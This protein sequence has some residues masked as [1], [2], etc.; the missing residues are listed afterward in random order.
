[1]D[2][3]IVVGLVF[4]FIMLMRYLGAWMLRIDEVITELKKLNKHYE[5]KR[6]N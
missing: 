4:V 2:L 6:N 5:E 3:L 1:M